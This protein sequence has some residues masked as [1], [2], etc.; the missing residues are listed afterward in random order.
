MK[1]FHVPGSAPAG[2]SRGQFHVPSEVVPLAGL[3]ATQL[4]NTPFGAVAFTANC[5]APDPPASWMCADS[6]IVFA[7]VET[8]TVCEGLNVSPT[9]TGAL[10]SPTF[11]VAE[12][13]FPSLVAVMIA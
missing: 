1:S 12:P 2:I 8:S 10:P 9:S 11:T 13:D 4:R 5:A 6:V 3:V 7:P